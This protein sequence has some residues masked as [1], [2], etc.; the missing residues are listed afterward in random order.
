[1]I[2]AHDLSLPGSRRR[3]D[4][5]VVGAA[6]RPPLPNVCQEGSVCLS[7]VEIVGLNRDGVENRCDETLALLPP[8]PFRQ[9]NSDPQ[10]SHGDRRHRDIIS[11]VDRFA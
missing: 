2:E 11:V 4:D 7:H 5:E 6:R 9:L 1:M 10:L 3:S 8:A